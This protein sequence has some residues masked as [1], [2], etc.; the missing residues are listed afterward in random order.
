MVEVPVCF[1]PAA[2]LRLK[3]LNPMLRATYGSVLTGC[4]ALIQGWGI[5]LSGGYHHC[6]AKSGGGFCIYADITLTI[7]CLREWYPQKM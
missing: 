5:N 6:S 1:V 3:L 7:K 2:L 4:A